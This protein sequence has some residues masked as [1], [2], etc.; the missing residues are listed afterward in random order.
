MRFGAGPPPPRPRASSVGTAIG[1]G[2]S[3]A[4]VMWVASGPEPGPFHARDLGGRDFVLALF[5][6]AGYHGRDRS[7]K[8]AD[9]RHPPDLPNQRKAHEHGKERDDKT[10]GVVAWHLDRF[11]NRFDPGPPGSLHLPERIDCLDSGQYREV[12]GRRRR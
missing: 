9:D 5:A 11:K 7:G 1:T 8:D 4:I 3:V 2:S 6:P 10:R 12:V